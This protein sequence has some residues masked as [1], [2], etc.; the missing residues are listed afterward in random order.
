MGHV[1][2]FCGI[3]DRGRGKQTSNKKVYVDLGQHLAIQRVMRLKLAAKE[4]FRNFYVTFRGS[5]IRY[6]REVP[7][8]LSQNDAWSGVG[9]TNDSLNRDAAAFSHHLEPWTFQSGHFDD[10]YYPAVL[11]RYK[12]EIV[13]ETYQHCPCGRVEF[14]C[15]LHLQGGVDRGLR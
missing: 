11:R 7:R 2:M 10:E 6:L 4:Q 15:L 8:S 3:A 9:N 14:C 13:F 1:S 12:T 5:M